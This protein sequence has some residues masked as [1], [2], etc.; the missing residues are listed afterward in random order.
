MA[1]I[2]K[3][4][5]FTL[6][7]VA[8]ADKLDDSHNKNMA[9]NRL[10]AQIFALV[11][12]YKQIDPVGLPGAP[13]PDPFT[14]PDVS[15]SIGMGTLKMKN[16]MAYGLS[17]FRIKSLAFDVNQLMVFVSAIRVFVKSSLNHFCCFQGNC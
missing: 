7:S 3:R 10:S 4:N 9:E 11:E 5:D 14:V 8:D 16:T 13:V 12:H 2:K 15:K 6:N 17:K 1:T